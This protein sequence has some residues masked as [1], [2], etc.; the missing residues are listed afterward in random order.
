M[1]LHAQQNYLNTQVL[2][3]S[4]GE[5]TFLL[6]NG[7]LKFMK[8]AQS[9]IESC[10]TTGKHQSLI[11]AQNIVD[12]LQATLNMSYEMSTNLYQLYDYIKLKLT[13]ANVKMSKGA[14]TECINLMTEL[15]DTWA[16][17]LK[18]IKSPAQVS[19]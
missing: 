11:K 4:P 13:E 19:S 7:C 8:Q 10:D 1:N 16:E 18:I 6:Y 15:R 9:A 12:E 17:A 3:A 2:T 5:L 14:I